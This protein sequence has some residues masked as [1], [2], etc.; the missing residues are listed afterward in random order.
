MHGNRQVVGNG[1]WQH[2]N[3]LNAEAGANENVVKYTRRL[4]AGIGAGQVGGL[5]VCPF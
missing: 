2:I 1:M 5:E 4:P 3:L